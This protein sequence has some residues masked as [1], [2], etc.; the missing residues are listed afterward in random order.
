M[1]IFLQDVSLNTRNHFEGAART[2]S[3]FFLSTPLSSKT[4]GPDD[5]KWL[6][7]QEAR[8]ASDSE[9]LATKP[10]FGLI[11]FETINFMDGHRST[12]KSPTWFLRNISSISIRPG[13]IV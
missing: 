4:L 9:G 1:T 3:P 6:A 8:F 12:A 10:N 7:E 11:S 5:G 2:G 13:L